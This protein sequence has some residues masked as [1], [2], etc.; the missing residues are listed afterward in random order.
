M[1]ARPCVQLLDKTCR[2]ARKAM[3]HAVPQIAAGD[4]ETEHPFPVAKDPV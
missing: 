2:T 1:A 3:S 4:Q